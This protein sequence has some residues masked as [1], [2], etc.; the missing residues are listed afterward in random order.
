MFV[1]LSFVWFLLTVLSQFKYPD[2]KIKKY[3]N[4]TEKFS[5]ICSVNMR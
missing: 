4:G 2:E 1:L 5:Y 3:A